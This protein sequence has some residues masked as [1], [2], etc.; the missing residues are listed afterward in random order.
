MQTTFRITFLT[1][2]QQIDAAAWNALCA[3]DYPFMRYEF[4]A[5]LEQSGSVSAD[6]GWQP[7]H[8]IVNDG[9]NIIAAMPLY[10][11]FH[12]YGE[13]VFDWSWADAYKRYGFNYYPK[14]INAI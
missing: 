7:Q 8:V 12:S 6:A 5:A 1:S 14:L 9:D 10:L 11:K 3:D 4:L 13:Y 2:L